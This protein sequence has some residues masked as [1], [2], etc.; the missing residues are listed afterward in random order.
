M[1]TILWL[2]SPATKQVIC[3]ILFAHLPPFSHLPPGR[4]KEVSVD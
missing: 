3:Q 4:K 1:A 2:N